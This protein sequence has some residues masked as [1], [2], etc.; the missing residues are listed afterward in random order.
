MQGNLLYRMLGAQCVCSQCSPPC[1]AQM[2]DDFIKRAKR[3]QSHLVASPDVM[4]ADDPLKAFSEALLN[5]HSHY[6]QDVH[7][8][9]WCKYHPQ[10][11]S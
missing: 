11:N 7:S 1:K 10:V 5:F 4:G 3:L 6:C 2:S 8:S 9:R